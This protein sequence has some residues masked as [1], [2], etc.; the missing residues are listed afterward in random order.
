M[1]V[2]WI[3]VRL[4]RRRALQKSVPL[5]VIFAAAAAAAVAVQP[6]DR[7][8]D[9]S[10]ASVV[11]CGLAREVSPRDAE[12][13]RAIAGIWWAEGADPARTQRFYYFHGDGKGLFRYGA[14]GLTHT[15]SFDY[16]VQGDDLLLYFRK[17][18]DRHVVRF[19][20]EAGPEP[21]SR[22]LRL[23]DDPRGRGPT[24]WL[25]Y[26]E[27][28]V[29]PH[30]GASSDP[31][32]GPGGRMWIDLRKYATG[33]QGF[34]LYQLR[35]PGID[36]RGTGWFHRGDFDD[37]STESLTYRIVGDR[38]HFHFEV[39]GQDA[40]T[41]FSFEG[42]GDE[43]RMRLDADPRDFGLHHRYRDAG[44]SFGGAAALPAALHIGL[45]Q[46]PDQRSSSPSTG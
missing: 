18:G 44:P 34:A 2:P 16:D 31:A 35:A 27:R 7:P 26:S 4:R 24:T 13:V 21:K 45:A 28:T 20:L 39:T 14:P 25:R 17:T 15:H 19:E 3:W 22:R 8:A 37:W 32:E 43:R 10:R 40:V 6:R 46:P 36:G 23:T 1:H 30:A 38:L 11:G 12:A 5:A 9:A 33:G 29:G 42:R 41:E